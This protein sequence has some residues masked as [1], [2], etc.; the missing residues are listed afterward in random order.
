MA[1]MA[2]AATHVKAA[3]YNDV[4]NVVFQQALEP[5]QTDNPEVKEELAIYHKGELPAYK[6]N[7]K[8]FGKE[9]R[10]HLTT[11]TQK[12]LTE[13]ADY[14]PRL[15]KMVHSNGIC[16]A[17]TW[18]ITEEQTNDKNQNY[19]GL[20]AKGATSPFIG[21]LSVALSETTQDKPQG[22][23]MAGKLF[24]THDQ[25][26]DVT[27]TNFFVADVLTGTHRDSVFDAPMTNKP[28]VGLRPTVIGLGL[29]I[30]PIFSKADSNAGFRPIN[31]IARMGL[32]E[33]LQEVSPTYMMI[34]PIKPKEHTAYKGIDFRHEFALKAKSQSNINAHY[35]AIYV[36]ELASRPEQEGW[37]HIGFIEINETIVSYGCDRQLHFTHPKSNS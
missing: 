37:K 31:G 13:H 19:T 16:M 22:F 11:R 30:A 1:L 17:G 2:I 32:D 23:G 14:Y 10:K 35:F 21:R 8:Q 15:K 25:E 7:A 18:H 36:S 28:K 3:S 24:G 34:L 33:N 6:V 4:Y 5:L 9:A 12:T 27:T 26:K 20:F 29:K